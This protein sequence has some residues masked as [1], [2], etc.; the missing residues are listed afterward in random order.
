MDAR[1]R[2]AVYARCG[3][4]CEVCGRPLLQ[5]DM[6]THHRQ[7][8]GQGGPDAVE[9]LLAL[10]HGCHNL[11]TGAVHLS[12]ARSIEHGWIVPSWADPAT[13]PVQV[14]GYR[15]VRLTTGGQY[16]DV[17]Y[18]FPCQSSEGTCAHLANTKGT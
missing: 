8:S 18:C 10:H 3:G 17:R 13:V 15:S 1:L 14:H 11:A 4:Y 7:L 2:N 9:N 16:E 5:S 12:V 6:A